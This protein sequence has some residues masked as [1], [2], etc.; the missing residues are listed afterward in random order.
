MAIGAITRIAVR[1]NLQRM[2]G[3]KP[4]QFASATDAKLRIA[5]PSALVNPRA[6][7]ISATT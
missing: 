4:T 6:F 1:S 3:G 7:I 2:K 5:E